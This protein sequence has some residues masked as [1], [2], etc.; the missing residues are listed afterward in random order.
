MSVVQRCVRDYLLSG[1][2]PEEIDRTTV[3]SWVS[4]VRSKLLKLAEGGALR[5]YAATMTLAIV[6]PNSSVVVQVGDSVCVVQR[7]GVLE[8]PVWPINGEYANTVSPITKLPEPVLEIACLMGRVDA[9]AV[10]SDG[11]Q[12]QLIDRRGRAP[13][14]PFFIGAFAILAESNAYGRDRTVSSDIRKFLESE[15]ICG[16]TDD[17]KAIVVAIEIDRE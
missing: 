13:H 9:V 14:A 16:L 15:L 11:L 3:L 7:A 6:A 12:G 1:C 17:D 10:F 4:L 8:I 2:K 5:D